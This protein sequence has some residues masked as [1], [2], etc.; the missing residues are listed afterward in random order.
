MPANLVRAMISKILRT[1]D[2]TTIQDALNIMQTEAEARV[3]ETTK[4][5]ETVRVELRNNAADIKRSI[6]FGEE[7]RAAAEK[8]RRRARRLWKW[9]KS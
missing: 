6:T 2:L 1:P 4:V 9:S 7:T 8:R 5:I 3:E